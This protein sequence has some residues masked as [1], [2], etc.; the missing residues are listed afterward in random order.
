MPRKDEGQFRSHSP[1][2]GRGERGRQQPYRSGLTIGRR[3]VNAPRI[4]FLA[5]E[6]YS[7]YGH[8]T[9]NR[10]HY[11]SFG[12]YICRQ[13]TGCN[14]GLSPVYGSAKLANPAQ[15]DSSLATVIGLMPMALNLGEGS[16]SDASLARA[17]IGGASM[18]VLLTVILGPVGFYLAYRDKTESI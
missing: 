16:E 4:G 11:S 6:C 10:P 7:V 17:L 3:T 12:F 15:A 5:D 2:S 9:A 18:S 8:R 1:K 13:A 14:V